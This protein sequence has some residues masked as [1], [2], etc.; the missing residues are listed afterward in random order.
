[1]HTDHSHPVTS[2]TGSSNSGG[3]GKCEPNEFACRNGKCVQKMWVC[4]SD[5]DCG[6]NSDEMQCD[7]GVFA[8]VLCAEC[9]RRRDRASGVVRRSSN[10]VRSNSV[11]RAAIIAMA[12]TTVRT[13]AMKS[14]AVS[15]C[16]LLITHTHVAVKPTGVE[17]PPPFKKVSLGSTFELRCRAVGVPVPHINWRLNWGPVCPPPR[18]V[19][20]SN[21]GVGVLVVKEAQVCIGRLSTHAHTHRASMLART[22]ARLSTSVDANCSCP[23]V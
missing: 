17:P 5:D 4:D 10:A 12:R 11:Y 23:T 15:M 6:D 21:D 14:D 9:R 2:L 7:V 20:T 16:S 3:S 8:H 22:L 13:A 19:Q 18:C 1:M